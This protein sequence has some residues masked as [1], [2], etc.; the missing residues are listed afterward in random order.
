MTRDQMAFQIYCSMLAAGNK[1]M[2]VNVDQCYN[3]ADVFIEYQPAP[4]SP[5]QIRAEYD[6]NQELLKQNL[7]KYKGEP[8]QID[9]PVRTK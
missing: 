2:Q 9:I 8:V 6:Q 3:A 5:E 7:P 4:K 1:T